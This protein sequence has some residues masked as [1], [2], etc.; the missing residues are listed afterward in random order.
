MKYKAVAG[1]RLRDKDAEV[2]GPELERLA[3]EHGGRITAAVV[4]EAAAGAESPLRPFFEWDDS[5]AAHKYRIDQARHLIRSICVVVEDASGETDVRALHLVVED[6]EAAYA[7]IDDIIASK[8][9]LDQLLATAKRELEAW[10]NKHRSLRRL[11]S[12]GPLFDEIER[13][14][15]KQR[16]E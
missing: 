14:V 2:V 11:K 16:E 7:P 1:S 4:L 5:R 8:D 10:S 3:G 9:L 13:V 12:M 15:V 6:G